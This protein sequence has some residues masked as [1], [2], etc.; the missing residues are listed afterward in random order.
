MGDS[1]ALASG[2]VGVRRRSGGWR[3]WANGWG[4]KWLEG[5]VAKLRKLEAQV[6]ALTAETDDESGQRRPIVAV[7]VTFR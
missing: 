1:G 4:V 5:E 2:G 7:F 6:E 3:P